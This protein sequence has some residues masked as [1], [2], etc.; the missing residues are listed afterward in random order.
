MKAVITAAGKNHRHLPL[1]TI[2]DAEGQPVSILRLQL[3]ELRAA[4]IEKAGIVINPGDEALLRDAAGDLADF[5]EC[6]PQ[7]GGQGYGHAIACARDFVGE[8]PFL[9]SIADHLFV[10][11]RPERN[12]FQQV[13]ATAGQTG[14]S[15]SAVQ[16]TRESQ[17]HS[18][19]V[20]AGDRT[21]SVSGILRVREVIEKPT[22]TLA[23]QKLIVSGLRA[24]E[25]LAFFGIHVLQPSIFAHL[26]SLLAAADE[27]ARITLTDAVN[28]LLGEED[29]HA[30]EVAGR[31]FDLEA[32]F[33]LLHG[34]VALAL[35]SPA[36]EQIMADLLQLVAE[37]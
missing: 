27:P 25:Y 16:A 21:D 32:P 17:I 35:K 11:D 19:G 20:V 14:A 33:G 1:Q 31:R 18:F 34:Q 10:S 9:L 30:I 28:H 15:V 23:E 4:G 22:P 13:M 24:G 26:E 36:R 3:L 8:E 7:E 6:L 37:R 2:T 29:Y 5:I 12:C